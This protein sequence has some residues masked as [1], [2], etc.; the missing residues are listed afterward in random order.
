VLSHQ[1]REDLAEFLSSS[2]LPKINRVYEGHWT[3]WAKFLKSEVDESDPYLVSR[4]QYEKSSLVCL[5][6]QR[7]HQAGHRGKSS[8]RRHSGH[9]SVLRLQNDVD[10]LPGGGHSK[11][12][13]GSMPD[14]TG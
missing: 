5:F 8:N 1:S 11:H 6:M 4:T 12:G 2:V 3:Q 13:K 14:E 9:T 7:R 10:Q